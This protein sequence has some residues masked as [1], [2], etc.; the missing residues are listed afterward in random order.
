MKNILIFA[1]RKLNMRLTWITK[2]SLCRMPAKSSWAKPSWFSLRF[3][4]LSRTTGCSSGCSGN[5]KSSKFYEKH[6]KSRESHQRHHP[7]ATGRCHWREPQYHQFHRVREVCAFNGS[8]AQNST[9]FWQVHWFNLSIRRERLNRSLC[10]RCA[11]YKKN[12]IRTLSNGVF[13]W[14]LQ[15]S[16]RLFLWKLR[17]L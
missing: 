2:A 10:K 16:H 5:P 7:A 6:S 13:V 8:G 14:L 1:T 4:S 12:P 3:S 15:D 17:I 9:I 11:I